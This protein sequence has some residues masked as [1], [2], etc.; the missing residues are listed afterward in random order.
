MYSPITVVFPLQQPLLRCNRAGPDCW[1]S[2]QSDSSSLP[3]L[4]HRHCGHVGGCPGILYYKDW[5][6]VHWRSM[7]AVD[8]ATEKLIEPSGGSLAGEGTP[9]GAILGFVAYLSGCSPYFQCSDEM[10]LITLLPNCQ[11]F[12]KPVIL[13]CSSSARTDYSPSNCKPKLTFSSHCRYCCCVVV[14]GLLSQQQKIINTMTFW[15]YIKSKYSY[16]CQ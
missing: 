2:L 14:V 11:A 5:V 13:H 4:I 10:W 1:V 16:V 8:T 9:L 15:N 12:F 7:S 3:V 6:R